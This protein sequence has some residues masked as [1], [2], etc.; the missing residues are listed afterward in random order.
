MKLGCLIVLIGFCPFLANAEIYKYVDADGHV[1]YSSTPIP[2]GKRIFLEPLPATVAPPRSR[3][4]ASPEGFP[5]ID[6]ATQKGRD[7]TRRKI[8][9]DELATEGKLLD[10]ARKNLKD[11]EETPEIYKTKD[12]KTY[13]NVAKY[14]EKI[15]KLKKQVELHQN[16]V[17]ALK[18][19]LS[20]FK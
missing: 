4:N 12:G 10:E 9:E 8:L 16:N 15:E 3:L 5:K 1:T 14:E 7:D 13:R 17:D 20:K 18:T 19:E 2:G 11:G 6:S